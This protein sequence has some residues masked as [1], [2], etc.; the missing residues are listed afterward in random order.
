MH[1]AVTCSTLTE[2]IVGFRR[3]C[4]EYGLGQVKPD[5]IK[6]LAASLKFNPIKAGGS[7]SMYRKRP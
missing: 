7:E 3:E 5:T 4:K 6:S 2:E 1:N